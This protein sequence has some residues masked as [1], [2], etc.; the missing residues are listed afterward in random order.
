VIDDKQRLLLALR[1]FQLL[2]SELS[3]LATPSVSM[4]REILVARHFY[5]QK[6]F[7]SLPSMAHF[8]VA[9]AREHLD[10]DA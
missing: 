5:V 9:C 4:S 2:P 6:G 8:T 7:L 3:R 1:L 10:G